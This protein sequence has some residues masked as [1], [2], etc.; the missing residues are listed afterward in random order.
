VVNVGCAR[1]VTV[2]DLLK[3]LDY[4]DQPVLAPA[5]EGEL[6]RSALDNTK[7]G[8]LWGWHP[9][10]ALDDGL[11]LTYEAIAASRAAPEGSRPVGAFG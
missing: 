6:Q 8:R 11:M 7:A 2:L 1:E 5:R 4:T 9:K 3:G 10:V